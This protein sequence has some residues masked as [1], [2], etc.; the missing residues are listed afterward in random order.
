MNM[1]GSEPSGFYWSDW[2]TGVTHEHPNQPL[3]EF[4]F[5]GGDEQWYDVE[6]QE[7]FWCY[8][9]SYQYYYECTEDE[10]NNNYADDETN[11]NSDHEWY[12]CVDQRS[13]EQFYCTRWMY[14][15][16]VPIGCL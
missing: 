7:E 6:E 5:S 14:I 11:Y 9:F 16:T 1:D 2:R 3:R 13:G 4:Y 15:E 10:F 8:D 12:Q